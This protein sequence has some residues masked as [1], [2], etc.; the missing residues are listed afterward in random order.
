[1][2]YIELVFLI[3]PFFIII[4]AFRESSRKIKKVKILYAI[5][6]FILFILYFVLLYLELEYKISNYIED[7]TIYIIPLLLNLICLI[8][9][10]SSKEK[11]RRILAT[12]AIKD[13]EEA[14]N[15]KN[16]GKVSINIDD[17][18]L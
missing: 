6:S 1:M 14:R 5:P 7:L 4:N 9:Y 17:D 13:I 8:F 12:D 10:N 16:Y 2:I 18:T 15:S 3:L 11:I